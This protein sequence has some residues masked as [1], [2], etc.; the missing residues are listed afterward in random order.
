MG[1]TS[2]AA[3]AAGWASARSLLADLVQLG[4]QQL[5]FRLLEAMRAAVIIPLRHHYPIMNLGCLVKIL[6]DTYDVLR[7]CKKTRTLVSCSCTYKKRAG[8]LNP[9]V[10][11]LM[12][13]KAVGVYNAYTQLLLA[14]CRVDKHFIKVH[15]DRRAAARQQRMLCNP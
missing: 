5:Q 4:Q 13:F 14:T 7:M 10:Y 2:A 12:Q 3:A 11:T 9:L 8:N 6:Q 1:Y 15:P